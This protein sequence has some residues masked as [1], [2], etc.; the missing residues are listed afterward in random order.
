MERH[1]SLV[2]ICYFRLWLTASAL[3]RIRRSSYKYQY[4][5]EHPWMLSRCWCNVLVAVFS[6]R[7][8]CSSCTNTSSSEH[9]PDQKDPRLQ[10]WLLRE[11]TQAVQGSTLRSKFDAKTKPFSLVKLKVRRLRVLAFVR[12]SLATSMTENEMSL[13]KN[14]SG[15]QGA[16]TCHVIELHPLSDLGVVISLPRRHYS[17]VRQRP[18]CVFRLVFT[19]WA[20]DGSPCR[21]PNHFRSSLV[22][23][24]FCGLAEY[25]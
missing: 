22:Q 25:C 6:A 5:I 9:R 20:Y 13:Q 23:L 19:A 8:E 11:I 1:Q 7:L 18:N 17:T 2:A 4:H 15:S 21:R 10:G 16:H 3:E 24:V 12:Y 14:Q